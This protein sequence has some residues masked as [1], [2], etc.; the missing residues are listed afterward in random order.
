MHDGVR[1]YNPGKLGLKQ[2]FPVLYDAIDLV[3]NF[4]S[5]PFVAM[6]STYRRHDGPLSIGGIVFG[7]IRT[8]WLSINETN[9][10]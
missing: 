4:D 1:A 5:F 10:G 2:F 7:M 9:P 8:L 3:S 6:D